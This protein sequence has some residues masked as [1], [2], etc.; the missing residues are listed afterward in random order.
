MHKNKLKF[1]VVAGLIAFVG[2]IE[3]ASRF[4]ITIAE[5]DPLLKEIASYRNWTKVNPALILNLTIDGVD[6]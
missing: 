6:S 5:E 1:L 2:S 3:I 4:N